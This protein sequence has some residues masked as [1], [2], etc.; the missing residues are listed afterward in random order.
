MD[1]LDEI[2]KNSAQETALAMMSVECIMR[3]PARQR[4][5]A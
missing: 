3:G 4:K 2:L 1:F 5:L